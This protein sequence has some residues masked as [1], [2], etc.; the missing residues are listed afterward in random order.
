MCL[1]VFLLLLILCWW[2]VG[3]DD[4]FFQ[5]VCLRV[6]WMVINI[7]VYVVRIMRKMYVVVQLFVFWGCYEV[8]N[9]GVDVD[10]MNVISIVDMGF[11]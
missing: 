4:F 3:Y 10:R 7:C 6:C 2:Y 8:Q 5:F 1:L 9:S 11:L